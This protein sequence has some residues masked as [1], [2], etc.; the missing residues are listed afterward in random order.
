[1]LNRIVLYLKLRCLRELIIWELKAH[2]GHA[3]DDYDTLLMTYLICNG[4][5]D[6]AKANSLMTN[7]INQELKEIVDKI[8]LCYK[9][10]K[11]RRSWINGNYEGKKALPRLDAVINEM[12]NK[13]EDIIILPKIKETVGK[14]HK[15]YNLHF[16]R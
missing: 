11:L 8:R 5:G 12:A 13:T 2:R 7:E 4:P 14:S 9:F 3:M 6:N 15:Y 16:R 10:P 1:M